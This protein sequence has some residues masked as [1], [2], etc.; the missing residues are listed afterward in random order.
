M[1]AT[2]HLVLRADDV[3]PLQVPHAPQYLSQE[4]LNSDNTGLWPGYLNRGTLRPHSAL[5]GSAHPGHDE[6]YYMISGF[7]TIRMGGD[8]RSGDGAET[9]RLEAG[10]VVYIPAN[11]FHALRNDSDHDVVFLTIWPQ[12]VGPGDNDMHD[13]RVELWGSAFRVN[14]GCEVHETAQGVYVAHPARGWDPLV[15]ESPATTVG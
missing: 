4:I 8:P 12:P 10:M 5:A 3:Q 14:E 15:A 9:Y 6:I 11:T 2:R 13:R 7:C 1:V